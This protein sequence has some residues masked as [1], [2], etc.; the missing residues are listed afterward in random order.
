MIWD[1]SGC[2]VEIIKVKS[3]KL[4]VVKYLYDQSI[5]ELDPRTLNADGGEEEIISAI[6]KTF[7][8]YKQPL[9]VPAL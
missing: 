8:S 7:S 1:N 9:I 2:K 5:E 4:V 6:A 3:P